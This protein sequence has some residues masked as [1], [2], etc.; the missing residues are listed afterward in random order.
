MTQHYRHLA[1][2]ALVLALCAASRLASAQRQPNGSDFSATSEDVIVE[3]DGSQSD[4]DSPSESNQSSGSG[5]KKGNNAAANA[6]AAGGNALS[7]LLGVK[8][9]APPA[10]SPSSIQTQSRS[11]NK[12][13]PGIGEE[14]EKEKEKEKYL[15]GAAKVDVQVQL[16]SE[17]ASK[18]VEQKGEE[19]GE[20]FSLN[21][22][23]NFGEVTKYLFNPFEMVKSISSHFKLPLDKFIEKIG[24]GLVL[25]VE[26]LL[27]PIVVTVKIVEKVF[28]PDACRL[29]FFC[30]MGSHLNFIRDT[31]LKFSP[32]LLEG[33]SQLKALTDGI[34]GESCESVFSNCEMKLKK[35]FENLRNQDSPAPGLGQSYSTTSKPAN[36]P[37]F[38]LM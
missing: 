37:L 2:L 25:G 9:E 24:N 38:G 33:S 5:N 22:L 27:H 28:V 13:A 26:A 1:L 8:K 10:V 7:S 29:K 15:G 16:A 36:K 3:D 20:M 14:K 34:K 31:V 18:A 4:F 6:W 17:L 30:S 23:K 12:L 11:A 21:P 35:P 32:S 19:K